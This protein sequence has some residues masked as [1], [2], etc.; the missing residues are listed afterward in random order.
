MPR[1]SP[2]RILRSRCARYGGPLAALIAGFLLYP[3]STQQPQLANYGV[4]NRSVGAT[5]TSKV[6]DRVLAENAYAAVTNLV[7]YARESAAVFNIPA[8][9]LL[10]ILY[11]EAAHRKP[12]DV[13][14]FGVAQ[15]GLGELVAQG[16]PPD[17][18][19][20]SNDRFSVWMLARKLRRLQ[21]ETGS[22]QAAI[23][24]HNGYSDYLPSIQRRARDPRLLQLLEAR[25]IWKVLTV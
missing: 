13:H 5:L 20:Y 16:L 24:L 22:L 15:L 11:E 25:K 21:E 10:A 18:D 23:T 3:S 12:F 9:V 7:P 2:A 14:T 6:A 17:P 1:F 19:L 4:R 8:N